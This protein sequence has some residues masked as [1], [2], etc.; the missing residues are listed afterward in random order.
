MNRLLMILIFIFGF[1]NVSGCAT[2]SQTPYGSS[3]FS[4]DKAYF[5]LFNDSSLKLDEA[6]NCKPVCSA[7]YSMGGRKDVGIYE[8]EIGSEVNINWLADQRHIYIPPEEKIIKIN[9]P[10]MYFYSTIV[11][12]ESGLAYSYVPSNEM[13]VRAILKY[14]N[15]LRSLNAIN[16]DWPDDDMVNSQRESMEIEYRA[17]KSN[18]EILQKLTPFNLRVA[19]LQPPEK[20][21][22]S[23]RA[24]KVTIPGYLPI[25][26][27]IR[28]GFN[29]ELKYAGVYGSDVELTGKVNYARFS[30]TSGYWEISV[31]LLSDN[32]VAFN[33]AVKYEFSTTWNANSACGRVSWKFNDAVEYLVSEIVRDELFARFLNDIS[34]Q[35]KG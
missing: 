4:E 26:E 8:V 7:W 14:G 31:S 9:A 21:D 6:R 20:F 15:D 10:G 32:G 5:M 19:D 30:S 16:F 1:L 2:H 27:Y 33:K 3:S 17:S 11:N 13:L 18:R 34:T 28:L 23:C 29:K 35:K 24:L 12:G 22:R 25:Q